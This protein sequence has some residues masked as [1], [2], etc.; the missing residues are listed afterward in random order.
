[1]PSGPGVQSKGSGAPFSQTPPTSPPLV[2]LSSEANALFQARRYREAAELNRRGYDLAIAEGARVPAIRFLLNLGSCSFAL[3]NHRGALQHFIRARDMAEAEGDLLAAASAALNISSLHLQIGELDG[4][5]EEARR[6]LALIE[7]VPKHPLRAPLAF[8]IAKLKVRAGGIDSARPLLAQAIAEADAAGNTRLASQIWNYQGYELMHAGRLAEADAAMSNAFRLR[9]L[10]APSDLESSYRTLSLLKLAQGDAVSAETLA[11]EA[12]AASEER[13]NWMAYYCR[14]R[15]RMALE[16]PGE[17]LDDLRTALRLAERFRLDL[18]PADAHRIS[19]D[20]SLHDLYSAFI[21][22]AAGEYFRTRRQALMSE[23]FRVAESGRAASL[24]ALMFDTGRYQRLAP[25]YGEYLARLRAAESALMEGE[26]AAARDEARRLR[27]EMGLIEA[28]SG[29]NQIVPA[30]DSTGLGAAV[31]RALAP[32]EA[33]L[34]FHVGDGSSYLWGVT[35]DALEIHRL[36]GR[37]QLSAITAGF[38]ASVR[39][40]SG[41]RSGREVFDTL[42]GTLSPAV[43]GKSSWMLALEEDLFEAPLAAAVMPGGELLGERHSLRTIPSA[44]FLTRQTAKGHIRRF[45]AVGD[46]LYNRADPRARGYVS[47]DPE[48]EL[49]RLAGSAAEIRAAARSWG[50]SRPVLLEGRAATLDSLTAAMAEMP[51]VL[52]F[53]TH[54]LIAAGE[55]ARANIMLSLRP[56]GRPDVITP[57]DVAA[58]SWSPELV[59]LSGCSSGRGEIRRGAGLLGLTRAWIAGGAGAVV[60]SLWPTPDSS[61]ELFPWFYERLR[62]GDPPAE[63]LRQARVRALRS[64]SVR[65]RDC[66][67]YV[68]F[69]KG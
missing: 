19:A 64:G 47:G 43:L 40:G 23:S 39:A 18:V 35:R 44:H 62:A 2:K 46:P 20:T 6:A 52:H 68:V 29:L 51:A 66:A 30:N 45:V 32:N 8:Q 69:G 10:S 16:R 56:D 25:E 22:A 14:G 1:M 31:R 48:L 60:A 33:L 34:S 41:T 59:V 27:Y 58:L 61:G 28:R 37:G 49:P 63:A 50:A 55:P 12:V 21:E 17:A 4:A 3:L 54:F 53:A 9:K 42:F 67:A 57:A 24:G 11:G 65:L 36:P 7:T 13:P 5:E 15:A 38:I 26:N